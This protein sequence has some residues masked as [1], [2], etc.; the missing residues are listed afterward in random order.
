[1]HVTEALSSD[2]LVVLLLIPF[3]S[4][5][6][7]KVLYDGNFSP[8]L[9]KS[10]SAG[11]FA[12]ETASR[13]FASYA[14][15]ANLD[16][17]RMEASYS[18]LRSSDKKIG[19]AIGYPR[20]LTRLREA[21]A[22]NAQIT[23]G[24]AAVAADTYPD[25]MS[26]SILARG[27]EDLGKVREV[28]K[29]FVRDWSDD[30][31]SEREKIFRPILDLLQTVDKAKRPEMDVL[32]PGA[33]L[34]RLAWEIS[35]IGNTSSQHFSM[36]TALIFPCYLGFRTTA[37]EL[38]PY[39]TMAARF[40]LSPSTTWSSNQHTVHPYA[41]WWS[42]Q[43]TRD[44]VFRRI[45]FPDVVARFTDNFLLEEGDFLKLDPPTIPVGRRSEPGYDYV[46]TLFFI[47]TSLNVIAT[48]RQ[49]Y[50]LLKPGMLRPCTE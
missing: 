22:A 17:N 45:T 24:I 19:Y 38:S 39:M 13:S 27:R 47:D 6:A 46:V 3:A 42:H 15:L 37:N 5:V 9:T 4:I 10:A 21:T 20:K 8:S 25:L 12:P 34:C 7:L 28:L 23:R 48:I 35:Q 43:H 2:A 44:T 18:K 11:P 14:S 49:I 36:L 29:H 50:A 16:I 30:G 1:M 41:H 32:V 31:A 26:R 33:G 40:L